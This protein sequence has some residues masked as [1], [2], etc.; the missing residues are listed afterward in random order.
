MFPCSDIDIVSM[1]LCF[2]IYTCVSGEFVYVIFIL[3]PTCHQKMS[4]GP[5]SLSWEEELFFKGQPDFRIGQS[6]E[7]IWAVT[8]G[9]INQA[10][11]EQER[12]GLCLRLIS[13]HSPF[14]SVFSSP[15]DTN[16]EANLPNKLQKNSCEQHSIQ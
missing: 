1:S 4:F 5:V 11:E 6:Q 13:Y 8:E 7:V 16:R 12:D 9:W 3:V 15:N 10:A 2:V 14:N